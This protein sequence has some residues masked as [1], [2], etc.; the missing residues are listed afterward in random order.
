MKRS[1]LRRTRFKA[2]RKPSGIKVL[3]D[4]REICQ[5]KSWEQRKREVWER[6]DRRCQW[7][8]G[9][10]LFFCWKEVPWEIARLNIDHVVKRSKARDDR[11]SNLRCLCAYHHK[12]RHD[13]ERK[14]VWSKARQE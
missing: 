9:E 4:G 12:L 2:K 3:P 1:P 5:G 6:D 10:G 8:A 11:M 13:E 7:L 14:L